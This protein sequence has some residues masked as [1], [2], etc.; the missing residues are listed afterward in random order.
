MNT[1]LWNPGPW[2]TEPVDIV[3]QG[4]LKPVNARF[5]QFLGLIKRPSRRNS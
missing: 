5:G 1:F 2:D 4:G 3:L